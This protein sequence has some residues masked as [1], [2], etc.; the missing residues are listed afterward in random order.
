MFGMMVMR[1]LILYMSSKLVV[2]VFVVN[3]SVHPKIRA[4]VNIRFRLESDP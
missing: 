3:N 1:V 2:V 4:G